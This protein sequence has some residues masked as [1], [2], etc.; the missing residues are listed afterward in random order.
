MTKGARIKAL[1]TS[2]QMTQDE[3]AKRLDTTKQ[4]IYKYE[5]DIVTNIP[6][7]KIEIMSRLFNVQPSYITGWVDAPPDILSPEERALVQI[8]RSLDSE[9]KKALSTYADFLASSSA[10]SD[11]GSQQQVG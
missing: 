7:D 5:N 4:T 11:S 2:A 1:R 6:L 10:G 9:G 3:L 8:Y